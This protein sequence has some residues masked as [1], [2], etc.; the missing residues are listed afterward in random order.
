MNKILVALDFSA[1]AHLVAEQGEV[2]ARSLNAELHLLHVLADWSYY[3]GVEYSPILGYS[4]TDFG[5]HQAIQQEDL[6]ESA[7]QYLIKTQTYL[8]HPKTSIHV[9]EGRLEDEINKLVEEHDFNYLVI[10]S[11]SRSTFD[12]IFM[13][14]NTEKVI[15]NISIPTLI[16]P[17]RE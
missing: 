11:H 10:G 13:G 14:S 2:L 6:S 9:K 3:A 17:I 16:I 8:N 4:N 1:N 5:A 7:R 15:K 12:A